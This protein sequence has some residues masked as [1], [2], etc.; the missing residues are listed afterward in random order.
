VWRS[1]GTLTATRLMAA[2]SHQ[3]ICRANYAVLFK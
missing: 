1:L 3:C 2:L